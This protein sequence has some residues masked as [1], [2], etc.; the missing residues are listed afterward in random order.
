VKAPT[1]VIVGRPNVGK[2][3]LFNRLIRKRKANT[4]DTPGVTRD[5]IAEE[6]EWSGRR[7]RLVDT[8]GLGGEA[9]IDLA[10]LVHEHTLRSV[11]EAD[12]V[13]AVLDAKAGLAPLDRD[14]VDLLQRTHLPVIYVANKAD[15]VRQQDALVEFCSLGIDVP[16]GVSAEHGLGLGDLRDAILEALGGTADE[17][18]A[19]AAAG[20]GEDTAAGASASEEGARPDTTR[21]AIVGRPN[22][23][24][25]SLLNTIAGRELSLVDPRPGT[26]RDVVDTA[27]ERGGHKYLLVDTA[28][29]RRPSRIVEDVERISV[30][31]SVHAIR[32]AD[33]VV[34]LVEPTEGLADQDA[35]LETLASEDGGAVVIAVNKA[36]LLPAGV[37][38]DR[39]REELRSRYPTLAVVPLLFMSVA[40][41]EGLRDLFE[42]VDRAD[43]AHNLEVRTT[44]LNRILGDAVERNQPPTM[45][46]GRLRLFYATQTGVRPP[47][48]T[49]FAN[50]ERVPTD[51][52]RFL[53]RT[54]REQLP[55]EGTPVRIRYR[56]RASHGQ[57]DI[58]EARERH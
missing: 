25:S 19:D 31:R 56:R 51:Y 28:G 42:A 34:L 57:R 1:V 35:R 20:A 26:T 22:V 49:I 47:K 33:V 18:D 16:L 13:V 48:F 41:R 52:T 27:I 24:K 44:D 46:G 32:R 37:S 53:E 30:G 50:R 45:S 43:A 29:M 4:L 17:D 58:G 23:G 36:D 5:P 39:M 3:T 14:T 40:R 9:V 11:A 21:I 10:E 2:S 15:G 7:V 6:V 38:R 54:L 8:G 12:L 55:L